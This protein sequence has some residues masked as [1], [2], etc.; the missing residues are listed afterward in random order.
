MG[1]RDPR[2]DAYIAKSADFAK[3]ILSHLREVIHEGCPETEEAIKWGMP[4][5]LYQGRI[6]CGIA[7]FKQHCALGFWG[8]R[9]LIGND[10]KRDEAIGAVRSYRLAQG[11]TD[12]ESAD[13]FRQTG[14]EAR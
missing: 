8:G 12:E 3:P 10:D 14:D 6:L 5:F 11:F 13:R 1:K 2:V 4:S 9:G 7:G